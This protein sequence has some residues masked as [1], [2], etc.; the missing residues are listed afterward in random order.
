MAAWLSRTVLNR[1]VDVLRSRKPLAETEVM[2]RE[3]YA[4]Q[5]AAQRDRT[6][7]RRQA[8]RRHDLLHLHKDRAEELPEK[9]AM[10]NEELKL[11]RR[12]RASVLRTRTPRDRD[13]I[14]RYLNRE[15]QVDIAREKG[16]SENAVNQVTS[17]F[18]HACREEEERLEG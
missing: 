4:T 17:R 7:A 11:F 13:V 15:P 18:R 1:V 16:M 5:A 6:K 14:S 2:P 3:A 10:K 9:K 8:R 12:G